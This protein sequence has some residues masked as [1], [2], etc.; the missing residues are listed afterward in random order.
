MASAPIP[1]DASDF[2]PARRQTAEAVRPTRDGSAAARPMWSPGDAGHAG[3][4][5]RRLRAAYTD[6][7]VDDWSPRRWMRA[8]V[9]SL[10]FLAFLAGPIKH[11]VDSDWSA[12][13]QTLAIA[14]IVA[15]AVCFVVVVWRNTPTLHENRTPHVLAA[16]IA[17]G[18][19]LVATG[20]DWLTGL[21][22][23]AIAMLLYNCG[24]RW[25]LPVVVAVPV[26]DIGLNVFVVRAT[27]RD[28]LVLAVTVALVG[29]VQAAFYQ[30]IRAKAE[31]AR[32]R[33]DLARLAVTEE[34][35]RIARDLH[36]ILGQRLSA[37]SLKAEL[38][39][40]LVERDPGRA[41]AEMGEVAAV[42]RD[43]LT[44]VRETVSG[45]RSLSLATEVETAR[46]LLAAAGVLVEVSGVA[47]PLPDRLDECAGAVVRE[48]VTNV[49][50]HASARRCRISIVR[51]GDRVVIDVRNGGNAPATGSATI[52]YGNG[53]TGLSERVSDIGGDLWTGREDG[54][55]VLRA[56]LPMTAT[57]ARSA[58]PSP[59][60]SAPLP[61][62][63]TPARSARPGPS[64]CAPLPGTSSLPA[65]PH[66]AAAPPLTVTA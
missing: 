15:F 20:V 61:M 23:Y 57:P 42:A 56:T 47:T 66:A 43:A 40:R 24:R 25:W 18:V 64:A 49:I 39:A 65:T 33:T 48:A 21:S 52:A 50:R 38:A 22:I 41:A 16:A 34:R 11:T 9:F 46:A 4:A 35:L 59:S 1:T 17:I 62:T 7:F 14:G 27:I 26:I 55:F 54:E 60:A 44:D 58:T 37:V 30:Q 12:A 5:W 45:Y 13:H 63:A 31:L 36:D 6:I 53:L 10:V 32:A 2:A 28:S 51:T 8:R 29:V 19:A 3:N